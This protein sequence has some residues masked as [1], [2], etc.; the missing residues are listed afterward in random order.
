MDNRSPV[1]VITANEG[2]R[3]F[4]NQLAISLGYGF[5]NI[6]VGSPMDAA[7]AI[8]QAHYSVK[9]LVI[10]IGSRSMDVLPEL[11]RLAEQCDVDA[12]V[13]VLGT[14]ND[15]NFYR[16]IISRGVLDYLTH[17]VRMDAI[18]SVF[19][20]K[21]GDAKTHLGKVIAFMGAGAGDGSSTIAINASYSIAVSMK[22]K[23]VLVDLDYQ[24]GMVARN[25]DIPSQYGLR[26]AFDHPE[27]GIDTT[28]IDRMVVNYN[29]YL[30]IISA[31]SNLQYMPAIT[32][33]LV[34]DMVQALRQRYEFVVLDVPHLW[35]HWV[36]AALI[37]ADHIVLVGQLWLKSVTHSARLL[38]MW[39]SLGIQDSEVSVVINRSGSKFK[40]AMN[41]KDFERVSGHKISFYVSNDIKTIVK[42]ENKGSTIIEEGGSA[43]ANQITHMAEEILKRLQVD[44]KSKAKV[45]MLTSDSKRLK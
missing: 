20:Q 40:E 17:P 36:S 44:T 32:A 6:F 9:Y 21:S 34:R 25:L 39:R 33:D 23:T 42:A 29:E 41:P 31:P 22:K 3:E 10:D 38:A 2:D 19:F 5:A 16:E 13:L 24:F 12:R 26:D 7:Q 1:L 14:T 4:Y 15:I 8:A 28:L 35:N 45:Q 43:L 18:R 37:S 30:D 11:D 27:R